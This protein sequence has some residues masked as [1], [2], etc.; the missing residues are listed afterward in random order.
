M[1]RTLQAV[2][3]AGGLAIATHA[4]AQITLYEGEGFHGRAFS[5]DE[6]VWNLGRAGFD[7]RASSIVIDRGRW[8]VCEGAR[9]EGRCVV[10]RRGQYASLR[11]MG[12]NNRISSVRR[13]EHGQDIGGD[14]APPPLAVVPSYEPPRPLYVP[15]PAPVY[16]PPPPMPEPRPAFYDVP[17]TAARAV[18]GPPSQRCWIEREQVAQPRGGEPNIGGAIV[19]GI[20]GG[21]L[22]HQI[23]GGSGK[24]IAT[25]GGAIAGAAIG[26]NVNR[27]PGGVTYADR[28]VQRCRT[29]SDAKP[30]YWEVT[31]AWRG[32]EH[33]VQMASAPGAT[34]RVNADGAPVVAR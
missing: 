5:T 20:V 21:V 13:I 30:A 16:V 28:D 29:V 22:G 11:E 4:A 1:N 2:L 25:A 10:L 9:F 31:Y 18:V 23:G 32:V 7:D 15:A 27:G 33:R 26:A 12:M 34:V 24:D 17:V 19:G 14:R 8:E 6:R 3:A